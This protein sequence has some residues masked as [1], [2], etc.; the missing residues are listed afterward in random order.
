MTISAVKLLIWVNVAKFALAAENKTFSNPTTGYYQVATDYFEAENKKE[1]TVAPE[2]KTHTLEEIVTLAKQIVYYKVAKMLEAV[3]IPLISTL[4]LVGNTLSGVVMFQTHNR[5]VT[6]YFYMGVLAV[7]DSVF[8][9]PGLIYWLLMDIGQVDIPY[10]VHDNICNVLLPVTAG[11]ALCGTYIILAMTLDRLIAVKWPLKSL[12]WCTMRRARVTVTCIIILSFLVKLPYGWLTR[13]APRCVVLQVE[14]TPLIQAYYWINSAVGSYI[15]FVILLILN[16]LI[17][18]TIRKRGKYIKTATSS[19]SESD[20]MKRHKPISGSRSIRSSQSTRSG[21]EETKDVKKAK[22]E[23]CL[24]RMLLLVTFSFLIL[25]TPV[26]VFYL[27]YLFIS[28][29]SSPRAFALYSLVA[30]TTAKMFMMNFSINFYL[31]CLGGSKF[32]RDLRMV[33]VKVCKK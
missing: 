12:T 32:R 28:P 3:M 5:H 26:Y 23:K 8:L 2:E 31:Y 33:L 19:G 21:S 17:I 14:R 16:L 6:C 29:V 4:G 30:H 9:A 7:T 24:T 25:T 20:E 13:P 15:P 1:V 22:S 27:I 10:G 18:K 11:S